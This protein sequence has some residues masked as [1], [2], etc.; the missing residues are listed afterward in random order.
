MS[1]KRSWDTFRKWCFSILNKHLCLCVCVCIRTWTLPIEGDAWFTKSIHA[2]LSR[3]ILWSLLC[4]CVRNRDHCCVLCDVARDLLLTWYIVHQPPLELFRTNDQKQTM[5][6]KHSN[7]H[8]MVKNPN[9]WEAD[10]L[11]I[12]KHRREVELGATESNMT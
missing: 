4:Y 5:I 8:N 3:S 1:D 12:Y 6:N 9:W 2:L 11:A 7:K 10:Q